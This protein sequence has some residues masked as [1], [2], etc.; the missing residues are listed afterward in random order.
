MR[1]LEWN[2]S[3][4][5]S[6]RQID[7]EG[8]APARLALDA[9]MT[10]ALFDDAVTGG[11]PQ[12]CPLP[13]APGRK[14]RLE[15]ARFYIRAHAGAGV[16]DGQ[17]HVV[18]RFQFRITAHSLLMQRDVGGFQREF[19]AFGHGIAGV[20]GQVHDDLFDLSGVRLHG[21]QTRRREQSAS[22][23]HRP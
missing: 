16:R 23:P 8:G 15:E 21:V 4:P 17:R 22:P 20:D 18:A 5:S 1:T 9:D 12:T 2:P 10:A 14:K 19:A 7:F 3:L 13:H 11:Q 6:A